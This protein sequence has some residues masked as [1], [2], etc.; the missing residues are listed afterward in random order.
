MY[1]IEEVLS[2]LKYKWFIQNHGEWHPAQSRKDLTKY[3]NFHQRYSHF[4]HECY[5]FWALV[6]EYI[7]KGFLTSYKK[8]E[9]LHSKTALLLFS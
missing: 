1:I 8:V 6:N 2:I 7:E 4:L 3:C 9:E 5:S